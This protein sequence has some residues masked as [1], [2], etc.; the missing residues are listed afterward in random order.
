MINNFNLYS[1]YYDLLYNDKDYELEVNYV[2]ESISKVNTNLGKILNLGSGTGRHDEVFKRLGYSILG[3]ELSDSM[4]NLSN[5]KGLNCVKGDISNFNLGQQFDSI[6][7]LFHVVSYLNS[8]I[9]ITRMFSCVS[10]HLSKG[11]VFL[12]DV[13]FTPAV[14]FQTPEVRSKIFENNI[15][16]I[17][18]LA[19]PEIDYIGNIV[20]VNFDVDIFEKQSK[21]K[22]SFSEIH[23]MRHF[24]VPE[25]RYFAKINGLDLIRSEEFLTSHPLSNK[26]WSACF[27]FKKL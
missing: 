21:T 19:T 5:N 12:M 15:I 6:L 7:S 2:I 10:N 8:N 11:G 1:Q 22:S 14:Y 24:S 23:S 17:N 4:V 25:L 13:W 26:T 16:K 9:D 18:R 20:K 3:I 27:T